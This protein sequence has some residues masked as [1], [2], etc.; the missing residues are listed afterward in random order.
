MLLSLDHV[1]VRSAAPEE[2]LAELT[3]RAR[4]PVLAEVTR[5]HG[6]ASGIVRAGGIDIEVLRVGEAPAAPHGYGV[7]FVADVALDEAV[8]RLR[9]LGFATSTAPRVTVGDGE[10]RRTWR[11]AQLRG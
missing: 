1:I 10:N 6:M 2:T 7:G 8:A 3:A 5:V 11:A 9:A 4:T